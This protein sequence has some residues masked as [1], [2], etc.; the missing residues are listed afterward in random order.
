MS[1]Y[2]F[3]RNHSNLT[4]KKRNATDT[5]GQRVVKNE[6]EETITPVPDNAGPDMKPAVQRAAEARAAKREIASSK[7][8]KPRMI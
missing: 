1:F 5:N 8:K 6:R 4:R 3:Y 7:K 2:C